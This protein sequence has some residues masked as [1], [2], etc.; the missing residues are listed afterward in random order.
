MCWWG[1]RRF[2]EEEAVTTEAEI[3]HLIEEKPI[4]EQQLKETLNIT[5]TTLTS[6]KSPA[7]S[8]VK[9]LENEEKPPVPPRK[10][11]EVRIDSSG[12]VE[13]YKT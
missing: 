6:D 11:K 12:K 7:T 3:E 10:P 9:L 13:I 5:E 2:V 1:F 8:D 4:L